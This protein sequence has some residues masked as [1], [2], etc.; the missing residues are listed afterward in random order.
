MQLQTFAKTY[1]HNKIE[2]VGFHNILNLSFINYAINFYGKRCRGM[3]TEVV[4]GE[5]NMNIGGIVPD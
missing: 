5:H 2:T 3:D 4:V 1:F